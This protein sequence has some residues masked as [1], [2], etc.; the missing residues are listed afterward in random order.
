[1]TKFNSDSMPQDISPIVK[2]LR[3]FVESCIEEEIEKAEYANG[4]DCAKIV[5]ESLRSVTMKIFHKN[6]QV[7]SAVKEDAN[8]FDDAIKKL[9][10]I[11]DDE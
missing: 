9:F 3:V 1:M 2:K 6:L 10:N 5:E 11:G 8:F 7:H 4:K